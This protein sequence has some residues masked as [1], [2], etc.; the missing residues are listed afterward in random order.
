MEEPES[1]SGHHERAIIGDFG[2]VSSSNVGDTRK[3]GQPQLDNLDERQHE[4]H[5]AD[6]VNE[7]HLE[8]SGSMNEVDEGAVA[9]AETAH[10]SSPDE[11][12][13]SRGLAAMHVDDGK[14]ENSVLPSEASNHVDHPAAQDSQEQGHSF[15]TWPSTAAAPASSHDTVQPVSEETPQHSSPIPG[16]DH[17]LSDN[18]GS[19]VADGTLH[20]AA[21]SDQRREEPVASGV[22]ESKHAQ[23]P[24]EEDS[25]AMPE[26]QARHQQ[27]EGTREAESPNHQQSTSTPNDR[28]TAIPEGMRT[29][30]RLYRLVS[31]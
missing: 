3:E 10:H 7:M 28:S 16:E 31:R 21:S 11:Q 25:Q 29:I 27:D 1:E 5:E 13:A 19:A 6:D 15:V 24:Q 20:T 17:H 26:D 30:S 18:G 14:E 8:P 2:G 12:H 23:Q 22:A 9:A 4:H